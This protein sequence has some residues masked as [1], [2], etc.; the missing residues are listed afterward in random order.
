MERRRGRARGEE[1]DK[2][3]VVVVG[4]E[5][6]KAKGEEVDKFNGGEFGVKTSVW[7]RGKIGGR[8]GDGEGARDR[9]R[10]RLHESVKGQ[11]EG[12]KRRS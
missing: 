12:K 8:E 6:S 9:G 7:W 2:N 11:G 1:L 10:T 5:P 4:L 3:G